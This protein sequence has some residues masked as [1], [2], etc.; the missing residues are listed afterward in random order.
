MDEQSLKEKLSKIEALFEGAATDGEKQAAANARERVKARL[1]A[2]ALESPPVE[3]KFKLPDVWSRR[4]LLA[5]L[6]RHGLNPFRYRGQRRT[7]VMVKVSKRFVDDTLWPQYQQLAQTLRS[8]LD[9]VTERVVSQ[10]VHAD[11]SDA[12][13]IA[14]PRQLVSGS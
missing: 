13:E 3:Y 7:T 12:Q 8:Y 2:M 1:E 14:E 9:E 6:R 5:L 10:V 4:L 11:A